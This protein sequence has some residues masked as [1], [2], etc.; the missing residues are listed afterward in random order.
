MVSRETTFFV[1]GVLSVALA[2]LLGIGLAWSGAGLAY[3]GIWLAAA[4]CAGFGAFFLYV[5]RDLHRY[6]QEYL[7]AIEAGRPPP[8]G[9][10]P[11]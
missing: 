1:G 5:G 9:G 8:P 6:R 7:A 11:V 4:I 2:V 10:P 3:G